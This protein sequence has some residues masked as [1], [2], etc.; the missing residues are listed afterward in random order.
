MW[1]REQHVW[2]DRHREDAAFAAVQARVKGG[3]G[4]VCKR[5][6]QNVRERAARELKRAYSEQKVRLGPENTD[7][8]RRVM[9][10][11]L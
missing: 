8:I 6:H 10:I 9:M 3:G 5:W 4:H 1:G 11:G 2:M 7:K